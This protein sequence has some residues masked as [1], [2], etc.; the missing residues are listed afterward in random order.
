MENFTELY[1][2]PDV[3]ILYDT[4]RNFLDVQVQTVDDDLIFFY[5]GYVLVFC[6]VL[7]ALGRRNSIEFKVH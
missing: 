5:G 2:L 6:Y 7:T 4:K 1:A 3:D